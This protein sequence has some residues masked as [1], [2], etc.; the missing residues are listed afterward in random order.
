MTC[1]LPCPGC[2]LATVL[3]CGM[4]CNC[5]S[6]F[7]VYCMVADCGM[8]QC[9]QTSAWAAYILQLHVTVMS[10]NWNDFTMGKETQS[11]VCSLGN[12]MYANLKKGRNETKYAT[13]WRSLC[14]TLAFRFEV[15]GFKSHQ[16]C[17]IFLPWLADTQSWECSRPSGWREWNCH[18][19]ALSTSPIYIY[20]YLSLWGCCSHWLAST[21]DAAVC[22]PG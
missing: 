21:V 9:I 5:L 20:I 15:L 11:A 2:D 12:R 13:L 17:G 14:S 18:S 7:W 16:S 10:S 3:S 8:F 1:R 22:R 6:H 4:P 19:L